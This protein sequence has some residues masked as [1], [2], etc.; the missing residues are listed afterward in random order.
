MKVKMTKKSS[1]HNDDS[2]LLLLGA[3]A[4]SLFGAGVTY[5]LSSKNEDNA[6]SLQNIYHD[7]SDKAARWKDQITNRG[8]ELLERANHWAN[9][10]KSKA[11]LIAYGLTGALVGAGLIFLYQKNSDHKSY[12][13]MYQKRASHFSSKNLKPKINSWVSNAKNV[14]EC[15][16]EVLENHETENQSENSDKLNDLIEF[17]TLGIRVFQN[18]KKRR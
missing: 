11:R 13:D 2:H 4:G 10:P 15:V 3:I 9:P 6:N 8:E 16:S 17:A 18:F 1:F 12:F 5:L 7:V 14:L